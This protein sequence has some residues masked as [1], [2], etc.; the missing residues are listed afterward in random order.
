MKT[1]MWQTIRL[2]TIVAVALCGVQFLEYKGI[3]QCV[4]SAS[5]PPTAQNCVCTG[6]GCTA[7]QYSL[8][9]YTICTNV[10][11]GAT[12]CNVSSILIGNTFPCDYS[13]NWTTFLWC[14]AGYGTCGALC[15]LTCEAPP[16][17]AACLA[18]CVGG[19]GGGCTGCALVNCDLS[20]TGTEVWVIQG[21]PGD[22]PCPVPA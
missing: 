4:G 5:V 10:P 20:N 6:K 8:N 16:V 18:A 9:G 12:N 2:I 21:S 3:A 19:L 13:F 17:C 7:S 22:G 14:C 15:A 1:Y 11:S